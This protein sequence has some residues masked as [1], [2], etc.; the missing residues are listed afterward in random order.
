M[1][2]MGRK[3]QFCRVDPFASTAHVCAAMA[4][5]HRLLTVCLAVALLVGVTIQ[6]VP[7]GTAH[8]EMGIRADMADGCAGA[9]F[10]CADHKPACIVHLGCVAVPALP[11][12]P[13]S[14]AVAFEWA[15]PDYD[16]AATSLSG[17]SVKPE[18]SPPIL[19]A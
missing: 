2:Y 1:T 17:I 15:L 9:K 13:A 4:I 6:L 3:L 7:C 5:L 19:A 16:F 14:I 18:L 10:P 11:A 12:S 8:A